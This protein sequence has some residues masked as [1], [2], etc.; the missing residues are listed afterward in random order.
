MHWRAAT[1]W[2]V[3]VTLLLRDPVVVGKVDDRSEGDGLYRSLVPCCG[4]GFEL[5]VENRALFLPDFRLVPSR[6]LPCEELPKRESNSVNINSLCSQAIVEGR[7]K[8]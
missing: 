3:T 4:A 8:R 7:Q 2:D 5:P 1:R 6:L